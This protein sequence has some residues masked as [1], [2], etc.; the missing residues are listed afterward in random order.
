MNERLLGVLRAPHL[1]EK[2]ARLQESDQYVFEIARD[3]TKADVKAAVEQLFEVTVQSVNVVN[4]QGK[5]KAFRFRNGT[6]GA[7]RKAY[8]RL[9]E[10]QAIDVMAKA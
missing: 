9:G 8:V 6:R 4:T 2:S 7:K 1:S 3:A 10:G 5:T